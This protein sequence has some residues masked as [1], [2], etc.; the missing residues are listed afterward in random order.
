M[1]PVLWKHSKRKGS[2]RLPDLRG[3][4]HLAAIVGSTAIMELVYPSDRLGFNQAARDNDWWTALHFAAHYDHRE[5]VKF[6]L[7]KTEELM[8]DRN[9]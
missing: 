1:F 7:D 6:L 2:Q 5:T 4:Q 8:G 3:L 9:G